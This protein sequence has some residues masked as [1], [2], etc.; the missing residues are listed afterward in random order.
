M[1]RNAG[2]SIVIPVY[3]GS[4]TLESLVNKIN[5]VLIDFIEYEIILV[6]DSSP[7]NSIAIINKLIAIQDNITGIALNGNYGQQSAILCGLRHASMEYTVIMD[8]DFEHNPGDIPKLYEEIIKGFDAVYAL[9][10]V[11]TKTPLIRGIGSKLRDK[12]FDWLTEK[13]KGI[14][15]CSYRILNRKTVDEVKKADR[16]FVYI[17]ME[18]L[19]HTNNLANIEVPY[20]VRKSSGH[21]TRKLINLLFNIVLY[22]S[23]FKLL[24]RMRK[25]G[26]AY[27]EVSITGKGN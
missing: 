26:P 1:M 19:K 11:K 27:K 10:S 2:I 17:S 3:N 6:D 23:D 18:I 7:D 8:D 24:K 22:Y 20:G 5:S 16:K 14:K 25:D 13:Q 4:D 21:N 9:N 15:V 12:I